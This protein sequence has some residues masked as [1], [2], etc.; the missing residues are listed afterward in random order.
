MAAF[1]EAI[2]LSF[3]KAISAMR[4]G[5]Y[6]VA[7]A[8]PNFVKIAPLVWEFKSRGFD[9]YRV[10][11]TGQHYDY[12]MSRVFFDDLAIDRPDYFLNV[13]SGTHS[14]QT[15]E[16]MK[17]FE[18]VCSEKRPDGIVV[19]GDVNSTLA[20]SL[21]GAKLNIPV[22]HVEA[23]LRSFDR[24]MPEEINRI[25]TDHVSENLFVSE[26]SGIRNLK[27]E[28]IDETRVFF[29]GNVMIDS[30][31]AMLPEID[32]RSHPRGD[33]AV[34]TLHRPA[35][36][37]SKDRL[38][39]GIEIL[40]CVSRDIP[41]LFFAHPRTRARLTDFGM[42]SMFRHRRSPDNGLTG[43]ICL[44]EPVGY[45]EF[46]AYVRHSKIVL[47][48]SGGIQ[49]ETTYLGVPCLTLRDTTERPVTV[50]VGTN[51]IAGLSIDAIMGYVEQVMDGSY[52]KGSIPELWDGKTASRVVDVLIDS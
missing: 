42:E 45:I 40:R 39:H 28:G 50:D 33:Y 13:G 14:Y 10:I 49:E 19:V 16:I 21:V 23:G 26:V 8:R 3:R 11:H 30:L 5:I 52:K 41:V 20:A 12:T 9:N 17:S 24:T 43:G 2:P 25:V 32:A 4:N 6:V 27:N 18:A 37:D 51:V 46:L 47:T 15:A 1:G 38:L 31:I 7:G 29:V 35:T 36:V 48:D 44:M 34:V 22:S